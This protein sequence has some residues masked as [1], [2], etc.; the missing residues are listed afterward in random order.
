MNEYISGHDSIKTDKSDFIRESKIADERTESNESNATIENFKTNQIDLSNYKVVNYKNI[1]LNEC[2]VAYCLPNNLILCYAENREYW[3]SYTSI[4]DVFLMTNDKSILIITKDMKITSLQPKDKYKNKS[5]QTF[6]KLCEKIKQNNVFSYCTEYYKTK[7]VG[8]LKKTDYS[9]QKDVI[10]SEFTRMNFSKNI[11]HVSNANKHYSICPTYSQKIILPKKVSISLIN[12]LNNFRDQRRLPILSYYNGK[13][14]LLRCSQPMMGVLNKNN[15]QDE[16]LIKEYIKAAD[17]N[18]NLKSQKS[19]L[20]IIDCRPLKNAMAQQYIMGGGSEQV[21]NYQYDD[22]PGNYQSTKKIFL[23]LPNIHIVC[24]QFEQML[25]KYSLKSTI[26]ADILEKSSLDFNW[27]I[28]ISQTLESLDYL[29]K[30]YLLNST[31][32]LIHCTHGWDRTSMMTSL[33]MIC[34]DPFY[35]TIKG[36]FVLIQLEWLD[37][38]FRFAERFDV[39][40]STISRELEK[41]DFMVENELEKQAEDEK[42][43]DSEEKFSA[44]NTVNSIFQFVKSKKKDIFGDK[45]DN[46]NL[47]Q[48]NNLKK[49]FESI[50]LAGD[51]FIEK[52][53]SCIDDSWSAF[54]TNSNT[55]N[56]GTNEM[57]HEKSK[58]NG[59]KSPVMIQFLDI[60][61]QIIRQWPNK[62]EYNEK[63][64]LSF[65]NNVV[66]GKF[67]EFITDSDEERS[68]FFKENELDSEIFN[69]SQFFEIKSS[70]INN[71]F[72]KNNLSEQ[73]SWILPD[74]KNIAIWEMFWNRK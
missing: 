61:C 29:L 17:A 7:S 9:L 26:N 70:F 28:T 64:L 62:F 67:A 40:T 46:I 39:Q 3:I 31:H 35:R 18:N 11:W 66:S 56:D 33:I 73:N 74:Y 25:L 22:I 8:E 10:G 45:F 42:E 49:K 47:P 53:M 4:L 30:E 58:P 52:K 57:K 23:N 65:L 37:Y 60:I 71:K 15:V 38:G 59:G 43:I 41:L 14:I 34:T 5:D 16:K 21:V 50:N 48:V 1:V 6:N 69:W 55:N 27:Y 19:K 12:H 72:E 63:F 2:L 20:M 24:S 54:L 32:L 13:N 51:G 68:A 44:G 36:F